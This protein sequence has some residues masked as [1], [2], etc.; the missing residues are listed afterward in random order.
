VWG[1]QPA[2]TLLPATTKGFVSTHDVEEVRTQ[3]Q[4][5]Q[6]GELVHDPLMEPFIEDLKKQIGEKLERAGKKLGVKWGDLEGVYGGEVALAL[7]QPDPKDKMSHATVLI[8]DITGKRREAD[9]LLAKI[10]ANQ[11][12][13]GAVRGVVRVPGVEMVSYTL[14][15]AAGRKTPQAAY[16]FV[17]D[18]QL[19]AADHLNVAK[20]IAGRFAGSAAKTLE[21]VEAFGYTMKRNIEAASGQRHHIRWF[22]EP[23]GYAEAVRAADGGRKKRGTDPL[24]ILA[25]EGFTAV[26]G[27][28]GN[29]FFG[30]DG[31]EVTHRTYV[32]APPVVGAAPD[33]KYNLSMR[34]LDFP[35][36]AAGTLAPQAWAMSDVA[37]YISF[38]WKMQEAFKYSE[39]LVDAI[40]SDEGAWKEIWQGMKLDPHGPKIDIFKDLV[41]HLKERATLL[42]DVTLPVGL[43]SERLLALVEV[44]DAGAVAKTVEKAFKADPAAKKRVF[45]GQVI[46]ELTQEEVAAGE[47]ELMIEGAGFVGG[48]EKKEPEEEKEKVLPN[49]AITV[50]EGH[51]VVSTHLD[52]V[53]D[54]IT[55]AAEVPNLAA[56]ADYLRLDAELVKLGAGQDSFRFF[57]RTDES[58]RATY[59]LIKQGK[60]PEA[61]TL[62]ARLLNEMLGPTEEGVVRKQEIDGAKLPDFD[63]V[64][65]YLGPGGGFVQSETEGWWIVGCLLKKEADGAPAAA[66]APAEED[67]ESPD[68]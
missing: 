40:I 23:L 19:V 33:H 27:I 68:K 32:Y 7:I 22:V 59:E 17:K 30:L 16:Y 15:P 26:Q 8:V 51:L 20:E 64:K 1:V 10:A 53:Q 39:T 2:E 48:P 46:W 21:G 31:R 60:L 63:K 3:F 13:I 47:T 41:D 29:V 44:K 37:T 5:T 38:N 55:R 14:P 18:D 67:S 42:A 66:A 57:A 34:M 45:K 36:S 12:A 61:E 52:F 50:F 9:A 65:K 49:M 4:K 58:Y 25:G 6:L 62:L 54:L 56:A 35:N 28:G 11:K 43:K 24:K